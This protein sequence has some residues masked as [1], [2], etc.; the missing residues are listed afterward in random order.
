[1]EVHIVAVIEVLVGA[2][3]N[4]GVE[5][6]LLDGGGEGG[7]RGEEGEDDGLGEHVVELKESIE[8]LEW[9]DMMI[10][11]WKVMDVD[12]ERCLFFVDFLQFL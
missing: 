11:C 3:L 1:M 9:Q 10:E 4:T 12:D 5:L 6:P 8:D 2:E 7:R